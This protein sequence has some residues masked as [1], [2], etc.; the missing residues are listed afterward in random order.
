M[1]TPAFAPRA[2]AS[3]RSEQ[4]LRRPHYFAVAL[5]VLLTLLVLSLPASI[6]ARL[7]LAIGS[8]FLPLFGLTSGAQQAS[9]KATDTL[10]PRGELARQNEVLR[11]ENQ[12]LRVQAIQ[13]D[14]LLRENNRLRQA[15]GWEAQ[16]PWKGRLKLAKVVS[17]DP[18]NWWRTVQIDRG[19]KDGIKE[20]CAV[21]TP[22]GLVGKIY[23]V[24]LTRSQVVLVGD[25]SCKVAALV[26]ND[27]RDGGVVGPGGPF[28]GSFATMKHLSRNANLKP[29]QNVVTSGLGGVFPKG[30]AIGKIADVHPSESSLTTDA[31][32]KLNARLDAL[33]EVWV[34]IKQ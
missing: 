25:P 22:E 8:L 2:A 3:S 10:V 1:K 12:Q 4:M 26:E 27:V 14:E 34:L 24:S 30:I 13:S 23:S 28:D 33:E 17:R 20:D 11:R 9:T 7:K 5:V 31:Q 15:L 29:G 19:T 16:S 32:I 6:T 18:A 21:L